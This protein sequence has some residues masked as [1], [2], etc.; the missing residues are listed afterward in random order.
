MKSVSTFSDPKLA[1]FVNHFPEGAYLFRQGDDAELMFILLNGAI[2]LIADNDGQ[3][4]VIGLL[5][6]IDFLGEKAFLRRKNHK[7]FYSARIV[8]A[9]TVLEISSK[10]LAVLKI[11]APELMLD[12]MV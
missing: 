12:I 7:R 8:E 6:A 5:H 10:S 9:A 1:K 2:E 11:A 3:N 4:H